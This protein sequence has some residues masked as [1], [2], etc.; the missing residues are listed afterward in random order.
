MLPQESIC[1]LALRTENILAEPL[2]AVA[3]PALFLQAALQ[4]ESPVVAL[5]SKWLA[6]WGRLPCL[7]LAAG[8][9][10]GMLHRAG[11]LLSIS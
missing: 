4:Q 9:K 3:A 5:P 6:V 2:P 7:A 1:L 10:M 11:E 8:L